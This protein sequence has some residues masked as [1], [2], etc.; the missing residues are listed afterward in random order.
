[1]TVLNHESKEEAEKVDD[2]EKVDIQIKV[3][4]EEV[5]DNNAHLVGNY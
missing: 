1:M 2:E 4:L 5:V 3:N